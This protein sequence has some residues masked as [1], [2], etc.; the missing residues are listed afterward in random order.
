MD[1]DVWGVMVPGS[2]LTHHQRQCIL[3]GRDPGTLVSTGRDR[4]AVV[5]LVP[6]PQALCRQLGQ[7]VNRLAPS[8]GL[9]RRCEPLQTGVGRIGKVCFPFSP[10]VIDHLYTRVLKVTED[11]RPCLEGHIFS[12][13]DRPS[14]LGAH[15]VGQMQVGVEISLLG[16]FV[17]NI[18]ARSHVNL[19]PRLGPVGGVDTVNLGA[20]PQS[21]FCNDP[22]KESW[23][24]WPLELQD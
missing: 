22:P 8:R 7:W 4:R 5:Q 13:E 20:E 16:K 9:H 23:E 14:G 18:K 15:P 11:G 17:V 6:H 1:R 10:G 2:K 24:A 19:S 21:H 3:E 12:R